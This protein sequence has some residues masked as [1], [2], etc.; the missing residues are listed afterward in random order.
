MVTIWIKYFYAG[1]G[2]V[3]IADAK[4]VGKVFRS[5]REEM[6]LSLKEIESS[7]SIRSNYLDAIEEGNIDKFLSTVYMYGFMRQY[8]S[9]LNLDIEVL[10]RDYPEVFKLPQQQHE[11]DY[12]IGTLEKRKSLTGGIKWVPNLLWALG[13]GGVLMFAWWFA[14]LLGVIG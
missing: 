13:I 5:K 3:M 10:A 9:Y 2:E 12:G 14:K 1:Q 4:E 8:A 11:F 7:T 6:N